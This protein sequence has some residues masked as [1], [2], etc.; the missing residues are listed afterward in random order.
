ML[1]YRPIWRNPRVRQ[2]TYICTGTDMNWRTGPDEAVRRSVT[3]EVEGLRVRRSV[4][5]LLRP[6][7]ACGYEGQVALFP[8]L[9]PA[10]DRT[11]RRLGKK[12]SRARAGQ[13]KLP[14]FFCA[15][16]EK[17][18]LRKI[19]AVPLPSHKA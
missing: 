8:T 9:R 5:F 1:E 13:R 2:S 18:R 7:F 4:C 10:L 12:E 16:H 14:R 19:R 15:L 17:G 3:D 6:R 11:L